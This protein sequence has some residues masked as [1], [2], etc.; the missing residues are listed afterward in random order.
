M[1]YYTLE[2]IIE[3]KDIKFNKVFKTRL[4]AIEYM[5]KYYD[6]HYMYDLMVNEEFAIEGNK[7]NVEYVCDD[8]RRFRVNRVTIA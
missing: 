3:G 6:K 5:F 8:Y 4:S 7:H 2:A 1:K